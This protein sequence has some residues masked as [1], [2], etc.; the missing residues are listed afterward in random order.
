MFD[1]FLITPTLRVLWD[2]G[3]EYPIGIVED[4][5]TIWLSIKEFDEIKKA[6][7]RCIEKKRHK[8]S[9]KYD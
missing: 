8:D 7:A 4:K 6:V 5:D 3:N 2:E 1:E 9:E